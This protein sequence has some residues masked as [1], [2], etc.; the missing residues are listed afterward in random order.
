MPSRSRPP[1]LKQL[2]DRF[3]LH[4][5]YHQA[6]LGGTMANPIMIGT[7]DA[8]YFSDG[9]GN[10]ATPPSSVIANPNP[11]SGTVNQYLVDGNYTNCSDVEQPGILPIVKYINALPYSAEPNCQH[12]HYYV[13]NN[14]NP[15]YL[16]NGALSG[17][18][19]V[20]PSSVRTIGDALIA[21]KISWTYFGGSYND[22]VILS[23][24]AVAAN[25]TSPNLTAAAIAD[26]AHALGAAYC[27][28]CNPFSYATSVMATASVRNAHVKDRWT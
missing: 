18:G 22:A 6:V 19:N 25:P 11:V 17:V 13:V 2:A 14:V 3:T 12:N 5:N 28:I 10:P 7:A 26:P 16:P 4:D 27:Q 23:N 20:P 9:A 15:G 8:I 1:L 21:K 24:E